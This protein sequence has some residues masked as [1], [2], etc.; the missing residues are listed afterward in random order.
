MP[1]GVSGGEAQLQ[2]LSALFDG[3]QRAYGVYNL[4][5]RGKGGGLKV[6]GKAKTVRGEV[7]D[8]L[9]AKHVSGEQG[10]GIVPV[11]DDGSC[12]FG[13]IDVDVYPLDIVE[14]ERKCAE[15]G[16]PLLPTR[17]KSGG[18]HLY[19]FCAEPVSARLVKTRLE[20]W[21]VALGYGGSEVF[22]K[23]GELLSEG[24]VGNW[25]NM[26]YFDARD[27]KR[28]GIYKGE[29]L[30]LSSYLDRAEAIRVTEEQ[31]ESIVCT[32]PEDFANGPPCLQCLAQRGFQEGQRNSGLFVVGVYLKKRYPDSWEAQLAVYNGKYMNPPLGVDE[33][34]TITKALRR[35][36]YNYTCDKQPIKQ[37]CNRNVCRTREFGIGKSGEDWPIVIDSDVQ[38]IATDPP[39]WIAT[40]NGVRVQL[41]TED[42]VTQ[43]N[44]LKICAERLQIIPPML[45]G[46]KW[47]EEMNKLLSNATEVEAPLDSSEGGELEWHLRQFCTVMPQAETREEILLG[48][49]W[50]EAGETIFRAA[51]FKR[52]LDSQHFR[53]LTGRRL[54]ARMRSM[55]VSHKQ[56][57]VGEQ[58]LQVWVVA[59]FAQTPVKVPTRRQS[60][61]GM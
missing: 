21:S 38:R 55:G 56:F 6:E 57:W 9:W 32:P 45:P 19:L 22:P 5:A 59:A 24:D 1:N 43:R 60:T 27:T 29:A 51:D 54:Y 30:S 41:F 23:Q 10:L 28:Y 58:N 2:R 26:P 47:R 31:L 61:G 25:I 50:T 33:I 36:E 16:F 49:P 7:T 4:S 12:V 52:Y 18:V 14:V 13:A 17:T 20:E 48:K 8:E 3:L 42:L 15:F 11:R 34:K 35:K 37:F 44:F 39:Y 53:A 46:E 40:I